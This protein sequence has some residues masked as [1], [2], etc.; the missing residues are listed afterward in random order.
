MKKVFLIFLVVLMA[1][2]L[3]ACKQEQE[4]NGG[5]S[6]ATVT[7]SEEFKN[8]GKDNLIA[9]GSSNT[10]KGVDKKGFKVTGSYYISG[11]VGACIEVGGKDDIFWIGSDTNQDGT[12]DVYLYF[13]EEGNVLKNYDI[14]EG[15][16]KSY[17]IQHSLKEEIFGEGGIADAVL[18]G[19][20]SLK[21]SFGL[22]DIT[23]T[24][25]AT[26]YGKDKIPCYKF[27]STYSSGD[28]VYA[29]AS[30]YVDSTYAVTLGIEYEFTNEFKTFVEQTAPEMDYAELFDSI[31]FRYSADVD[32]DLSDYEN[33]TYTAAYNALNAN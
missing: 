22:A 12:I 8:S 23:G 4:D 26:T 30:V 10:S 29:I 11:L 28:K 6:E 9:Q 24:G 13:Y 19:A 31:F 18:F 2:A 7:I 21:E 3:V 32:Y 16:W 33:A 15:V 1:L 25:V 20:F 5:G 27:T 14:S 17:E